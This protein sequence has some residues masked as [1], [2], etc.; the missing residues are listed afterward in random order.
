MSTNSWIDGNGPW[1]TG[2]NWSG[3][4]PRTTDDVTIAQG[5]PQILSDAGTVNSVSIVNPGQLGVG[6]GGELATTGAFSNGGAVDIE[7]GGSLRTGANF[8]NAGTV[9]VDA[10][11]GAGGS[12]VA[13][14]GA[15]TNNPGLAFNFANYIQ[16]GNDT[17]SVPTTVN[18]GGLANNGS[19]I[20]QGGGAYQATLNVAAAA[21]SGMLGVLSG[22]ID[23]RGNALLEF[24]SGQIVS[25]AAGG[26]LSL[27]GSSAVVA[28]AGGT[29]S[30]S[31]LTGLS[32]NAGTLNLED[33]ASITTSGD[34]AND[35]DLTFDSNSYNNGNSSLTIGG[36][37]TNNGYLRAGNSGPAGVS[38]RIQAAS[39][40]NAGFISLENGASIATSGA[41]TNANG[42]TI[43]LDAQANDTGGS[44]V[45]I[46]GVLNNGGTLQIGNA[47]LSA[48]T[49]IQ[50]A[51]LNNSASNGVI[52]LCGGGG[53]GGQAV[54]NITGAA[55]F[56]AAGVLTGAVSLS[57][58]A[59]LNFAS[60]QITSIA[61]GADLTL[62]GAAA[63]V[64][65]AA[66]PLSN[67]ALT[68]LSSN[69]G[70]L[71]LTN[72]AS[73]SMSGGLA[74]SGTLTLYSD[75]ALQT[76]LSIGGVA[77]LGAAGVLTGDVYISGD[78]LLAFASGQIGSIAAGAA[79]SIDG[80]NAF[81]ADASDRTR[82]SA[83]TGL[84]SNAGSLLIQDGASITTSG[85]VSN[86]GTITLFGYGP[87]QTLLNIAGAAG[88]GAPGVLT[89]DVHLSGDALLEFASG[90]INSIA[91]GSSLSIDGTNAFVADASNT[92]SNS[93]LAGLSS[94]AG[95]LDLEDG[96]SATLS[97]SFANAGALD[98]GAN[99]FGGGGIF[100][101]AN[102]LTNSGA[103]NLGNGALSIPDAIQ[104]ASLSNS[105]EISLIG[106]SAANTATLAIAG[107]ASND[108]AIA[109]NAYA[110]ITVGSFTQGAS[111]SSSFDLMGTAAGEFGTLAA[112]GGVTLRGGVLDV[113]LGNLAP[114]AGQAFAI[115]TFASE[116]L[117]GIY[118]SLNGSGPYVDIG[119]GLTLGV[120]YND[121][122][123]ATELQIV[124][125][126]VTTADTVSATAKWSAAAWSNGAPRFYSDVAVSGAS[127]VL[128]LDQDATI[129]SLT[130]NAGAG[131]T[132]QA[133]TD[134]SIGTT[135][136]VA[137]GAALTI[138]AK[139]FVDGAAANDGSILVAGKILDIRGD[140]TGAGSLTIAA[141]TLELGG[142]SAQTVNFA[143]GAAILKL[144]HAARF[145]GT[146][147]GLVA[148]DVLDL[149][150]GVATSATVSG[151]TLNITESN[152][153]VLHY[154]LANFESG[155]AFTILSD[156]AGGSDLVV[157]HPAEG[158]PSAVNS[159]IVASPATL[160]ADGS[161]TTTLT[162]T[163]ENA[164]GGL[165]SG[166][167][168][169][170]ASA[171]AGDVFG[172]TTGVTN[173]AGVFT[174]T[175]KSTVAAVDVITATE[176]SA[177]ETTAV[178]FLAG[179]PSA[180]KSS[181]LTSPASL[182]AD[183]SSTTTLTV[184]VRDAF[185]NLAPNTAVALSS[186]NAGDVFG[187]TTGVTNAAGVFTTTLKSTVAAVDTITATEGSAQE[188]AIVT[189][190][191][192]APSEVKSSIVAS[193]SSLTADGSS[194]TT[195]TVTVRDAFGNLAPNTAVAL[196]SANAG[197][198]FGA[199]TGVTNAAGVFTTTLKSTVS[200]VDTITAT[201]GSAQETAI[202]TFLAGAPSA[203]KST[204][205]VSPSSLTAD[206]STATT[207][208]VTVRDA[209][210]NVIPNAAVAL[211]S[212][213]AGDVFGATSGLTNAAGVFATTLRS[214]S[215]KVDTI[216]AA[217]GSVKETATVTFLAGAPSA[218]KSTLVA[219]PTSLTADG[220]TMTTL[221]VT[222]KDAL[223]NA[224]PGAP[225]TLS[226]INAGD[227][228]GASSGLTNAAGVFTTTLKS[229]LAAIDTVTATEGGP[230]ETSRV[231]FLAGPPSAAQ[232][233]IAANPTV[234][235][236][237][238]TSTTT[239]TMTVKDAYGN[240]LSGAPVT[241]SSTDAG[242]VFGATTGVTNSAGVFATTLKS[243]LAAVDT[244]T[245]TEGAAQETTMVTF[246]AGGAVSAANSSIVASLAAVNA[247]GSSTTTLTV[248]VK[249]ALG[250]LLPGAAVAL[251]STNSGDIFGATSGVA[252]TTG[253]FTT[254]L[255]STLAAVDTITA[256]EGSAK[257]TTQ[258]T[259]VTGNIASATN[260]SLVSSPASLTA[261]GLS[262]TT[263]TVT[264]KDPLGNL[265]SG[266]PVTLSSTNT[267][268]AF[269]AKTGVTNAAGVFTTTLK[270]T[271]AAVDAITATEGSVRETTK[272]TF[273]A[274]PPAAALSWIIA[275]P[276][277]L[278]ADG[279]STTTIILRVKDAQGNVV[280][281][282]AVALSST[283]AG[284]VFGAASGVTDGGGVFSTTLKSTVAA[285]DTVTATAGSVHLTAKVTFLVGPPATAKS[286]IVASPS[287][288]TADGSS[289]TTLTVTVKDAA[290]NVLSG[291]VV[292]LSS[293][294]TGDVFGATSGVTNAS[295]VFTTTLKS[296]LAAIDTI[297]ATEGSAR[298]TTAVT[299]L[300]GPPLAANSAIV[301]SP[302]SPTADGVS[303]T[304][305]TV[306]V[307]DAYGNV[308]PHTA[309]ALSSA[310]AGDIFGAT[311]GVTDA[312]GVFTTT[313][314]STLAAVDTIT[315]TEGNAKETATVTFLAGAPA[316]ATSSIV[317]SPSS[318]KADGSSVTTLTV[319]VKDAYGNVVPNTAVTLSSTDAGDIFGATT[320]LT[321]AAG[322][323]T[324]TLKSTVAAVD[325]VTASEGG[326]Q[327]TATV[328]FV[329]PPVAAKSSIVA[330]PSSLTANGVSTT[331]LTVT[332]KDALGNLVSVA[333]VTLSSTDAGDVFGA[334]T[335]V[336]NAAGVFTTTLKSTLAAVDTIT[337]TEGGAQETTKVTF[338]AGPPA[339]TM[340]WIIASPASLTADGVSTTTIVVRVKD[341]QGNVVP[342]TPVTLS[343]TDPGD[344]FGAASGLTDGGGLFSAT[345]KST[346]AGAETVTAT[347]GVVHLTTR[348]TFLA[349]PAAAAAFSLAAAPPAVASIAEAP[350][351]TGT[352]G[353]GDTVAF[354]LY[355]NQPLTLSGGTGATLTL[356]DGGAAL[357]DAAHSTP[358]MLSFA[359]KVAAGQNTTSLAATQLNLNG[360]T[361]ADANS[362]PVTLGPGL[363]GATQSA[364]PAV[365]TGGQLFE[366]A[367]PS[368]QTVAFSG[369]GA[370]T[371]DDSQHFSGTIKGLTAADT[372]DLRDIAFGSSGG[373]TVGY[374][375]DATR[376]MSTVS[377]GAHVAKI[378]LL[379]NYM[380]ST[381][382]AS[383]DG[384]GGTNLVDPPA[385][386]QAGLA[387]PSL[388]AA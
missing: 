372:L 188:T 129:D 46:G 126:P 337:A 283:D 264:V 260:S 267:G 291:V 378:A 78:S 366:I 365:N 61:G 276:T 346:V 142:A 167:V 54:L 326:A 358:S 4:Q 186:P 240:V 153:A 307:R 76:L 177:Q 197:D 235:N 221:T 218:T 345:L 95:V 98:V 133:N 150:D 244:V 250:N 252:N 104:A 187:A 176:G 94:N 18:V 355:P 306:T 257:E 149:A 196:S 88:F 343:S 210:G 226:S 182:T 279:S 181:I 70:T 220:S 15:L 387:N 206:G 29:G 24:T 139:A 377:D 292:A 262:T 25:I 300:A 48:Q 42:A 109:A 261:D 308:V 353:V 352:L 19:L 108:G 136:V 293:A 77:G 71:C 223:G 131:L 138:G 55:G 178:T 86:S 34:F 287:S 1:T 146:L 370:L 80:S 145:T 217:E 234:V 233:S 47:S 114:A 5:D 245:A 148:T 247:D 334:K 155:D 116:G 255:K 106:S 209:Y 342:F 284:D 362:M 172:A 286:S 112:T 248:T 236:A 199:T 65:D 16:I 363:A 64:A 147:S 215:A 321:N 369:P 6:T 208:A 266:A 90:Q 203:T 373:P 144:D 69:V 59:L 232:S 388:H 274:G 49:K 14:A 27:G 280:P 158:P 339:A 269:G 305:L 185:G 127:T 93:A 202:V 85:G 56:G 290:G 166:V 376:G 63:F 128:T 195:L 329:G 212:I 33:G 350:S 119:D 99:S 91:A 335:G 253:V 9:L 361:V 317:A 383:Y 117:T 201:E 51:S 303:T 160:T 156:G 330:S 322:V 242:D 314:K 41:F 281:N 200:A 102:A 194:A 79:L 82:N 251:T 17:L 113:T 282:T 84:S 333:P 159:S 275:T 44:G 135:I 289:M 228:F 26:G 192:G 313:L 385:I 231:T 163:V 360:A 107:A 273:A 73:I 11:A 374:T 50:A 198:V 315:A 140:V 38:D 239:L 169:T 168:V 332:V 354:T 8:D 12:I 331:T 37:L 105:G 312:S 125:S 39:L 351:K 58:N 213:N 327:E 268:D 328:T 301:A 157:F 256:I 349:V 123:G 45:A 162:V 189:F 134:L 278:T 175:L 229:T 259:F 316:A 72:G 297:T 319:M 89:G 190:L 115:E 100:T 230:Q 367:G 83:L 20:I 118:D 183:G 97:G 161:S 40:Q 111:G 121:A 299:F 211:S 288:L 141:G 207:L 68:G 3:G 323:F 174:T 295:G 359:Y 43:G 10:A 384:H 143:G 132:S 66:Q 263:L 237:D 386:Q 241:L 338:V 340:S 23:L 375:G 96:A 170:L 356:N 31:A 101:I 191:A 87:N 81:V 52:S 296:T 32:E 311:S 204:L 21:G 110:R 179:A 249:D 347:A 318:L 122:A 381:F 137:G 13:I 265:V 216:T 348:V 53:S 364:G 164:Q 341:A 304:T 309:V 124:A 258:V 325:T 298:E 380:A 193:L 7:N 62:N 22:A 357:F 57:G 92:T 120:V 294:D 379:G 151:S 371:L 302:L 246:V 205:V 277:S 336:T 227:V 152:G 224:V 219:S 28:D 36:A 324:T 285:I 75:G 214:T 171:N 130:L 222:V 344:V 103:I 35:G 238:G 272:V 180:L 382:V 225:V 271:L 2:S 254:T 74:N 270:S 310:N 320:G 154:A 60:G 184:T 165:L 243:T 368:A 30:N 173:A 67:S